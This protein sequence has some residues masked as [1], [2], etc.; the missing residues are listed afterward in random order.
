[1]KKSKTKDFVKMWGEHVSLFHLVISILINIGLVLVSIYATTT[2][3]REYRLMIGL[4]A[5]CLAL[6]ANSILF[7]PNRIVV[8]K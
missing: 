7:K 8:S 5:I 1:M 4:G 6:I 3:A 2:L